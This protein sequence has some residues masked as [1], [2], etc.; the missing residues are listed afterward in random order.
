M[1]IFRAVSLLD[2][3]WLSHF[4]FSLPSHQ[5][6]PI[7]RP[8]H[9]MNT[10]RAIGPPAKAAVPDLLRILQDRNDP[11]A[12]RFS[13]RYASARALGGIRSMPAS[14]VPALCE[15]LCDASPNLRRGAVLALGAM[16]WHAK[17]A[18]AAIEGAMKDGDADFREAAKAALLSGAAT[19][20]RS[21]WKMR[22]IGYCGN[23]SA[24]SVALP[25]REQA[26]IPDGWSIASRDSA[27]RRGP[28]RLRRGN[29]FCMLEHDPN[30]GQKLSRRNTTALT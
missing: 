8:R 22:S 13:T 19:R 27:A 6:L 25:S 3:R 20:R 21:L 26:T 1:H 12:E 11:D 7:A 5:W 2:Q 10:L 30:A 17:D 23:D 24:G 29:C 28:A 15:A 16:S 9:S 14:I 4:R 18:A